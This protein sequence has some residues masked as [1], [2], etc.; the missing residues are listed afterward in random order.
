MKYAILNSRQKRRLEKDLQK[1]YGTPLKIF[2]QVELLEWGG[3]ILAVTR[4]M[5]E[6]NWCD[7]QIESMGLEIIRD[8]KPTV[9]GI[10]LFFGESMME[11]VDFKTAKDFI[12]GKAIKSREKIISY[13]GKP[14]DLSQKT[15]DGMNIR[16]KK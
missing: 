4:E 3:E 5:L 2:D 15:K 16:I 8:G 13:M 6:F 9:A 1:A 11:D 14:I 10:Q 7:Y 12:N